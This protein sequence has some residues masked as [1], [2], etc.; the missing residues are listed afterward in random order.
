VVVDAVDLAVAA[1]VRR[2][3]RLD[4]AQPLA[5]LAALASVMRA[6]RTGS[7]ASR[8]TRSAGTPASSAM[9]AAR[10]PSST[11]LPALRAVAHGVVQAAVDR[12]V[13]LAPAARTPRA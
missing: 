2:L 9:K 5:R 8:K 12:V 13:R 7:G 10:R 6:A 11:A 3:A 1:R 4:L